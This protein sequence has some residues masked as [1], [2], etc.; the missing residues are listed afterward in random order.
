MTKTK[1]P[2]LDA[3]KL[4]ENAVTSI[5]LGIEDF[6]LSI[7]S[8]DEHGNPA[9]ALS[10]VRNL[11]A[12]M[13]L[14]FK[15]KIADC[16]NTPEEAFKLIHNPPLKILPHP[17]GSGGVEWKPDGKFKSTTIDVPG[18][19]ERF[20]T[21]KIEVDWTSIKKL[22]NCRNHL[23]HLHPANTLGEV[24][25][26]VADLFPVLTNFVTYEL[27]MSPQEMLGDS[28]GIMLNHEQFYNEKKCECDKSWEDAGIPAGMKKF[29]DDC[30]CVECGSS[31]IQ[32]SKECLE[33][34]L[35][36]EC[37]TEK[38]TYSCVTC[39]KSELFVPI[40]FQAFEQEY[41]YWPPDGDEPTYEECEECGHE[42]FVIHEQ[43]CR[44]CNAELE[45]Q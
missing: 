12:G 26:F 44:W 21:F 32:A 40:L 3:D 19:E 28:W 31:L 34:G 33:E 30:T 16:V 45:Y 11:Y 5:Q 18:I 7:K 10:A 14:L 8:V 17:D 39:G 22:Q 23:E 25:G 29:K 38:F 42:T 24:A 41:F 15:Y 27:K 1:Q 9:R 35:T 2:T 36:V 13:L 6:Q 37:D 4:L 20:N 43:S